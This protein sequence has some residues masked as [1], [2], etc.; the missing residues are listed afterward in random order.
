MAGDRQIA[1]KSPKGYTLGVRKSKGRTRFL[2]TTSPQRAGLPA[3]LR[4][5]GL[6]LLAMVA[7]V[8]LS[9]SPLLA[10][11]PQK[12]TLQLKWHHQFQFAGYY[13]AEAKGYYREAG[14]DVSFVEGEPHT[15]VVGEVASGRAQ[16]GV[17]NSSL[18]LARHQG[19]PVVALAAFF[20]HSPL[21]LLARKGAGIRSIHDLAGKRVLF[22]AGSEELLAYLKRER[23]PESSL[24]A[25]YNAFD[26][27][28]L[29]SGQVDAVTAYETVEPFQLGSR[30]AEFITFSPRQGGIDFYGDTLFTSEREL[31]ASPKRVANFLSASAR[32]WKYA[33]DNPEEVVDL[34]L[35]RYDTAGLHSKEKLLFEAR[36]T[37]NLVRSDLVEP[38]Y[39]HRGRWRHIVE[40]YAELGAIPPDFSLEGFLYDPGA[41]RDADRAWLVRFTQA[42]L[43]VIGGLCI[44]GVAF[45]RWNL[46][47]RREVEARQQAVRELAES[48][49]RFRF[50][51]EHSGDVVWTMDWESE[52]LTF[53]S[54]SVAHLGGYSADEILGK[55]AWRGL[56]AESAER[57]RGNVRSAVDRWKSG[58]RSGAR[59]VTEVALRH[60]EGRL[61]H[62]EVVT[63]VHE[64]KTGR[65]T[66]V[67]ITRDISARKASEAEMERLALYDPLTDLPNRR[68]LLDR[69]G[70]A[71]SRAGREG[72]RFALLFLDLD[73][74]KPINDDYGHD[75]GD[76]VLQ[77]AARRM[78]VCVRGADTVARVG[79]DEF[80]VILSA[81]ENCSQALLVAGKIHASLC[82]P[83][84]FPEGPTVAITSSIGVALYPDHGKNQRDLMKACDDAMYLAKA[85]GKNRVQLAEESPE[86]PFLSGAGEATAQALV[87]F[88]WRRAYTSGNAAIDAEHRELFKEINQL[89]RAGLDKEAHPEP[90]VAAARALVLH[91]KDHFSHEDAVL[92]KV[93]FEGA[94]A[95]AARHRELLDRAA[96]LQW[97]V[98][99]GKGGLGEWVDFL[100]RELVVGHLLRDDRQFFH[101]L[102]GEPE[103]AA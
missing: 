30:M 102:K 17:G 81:I 43:A 32:G 25:T 31:D 65:L 11:E 95:H 86:E 72:S 58:D 48:E 79:G 19:R 74:F 3:L 84:V 85:D 61:I 51:A 73:R 41:E 40:S 98:V 8:A 88:Q 100:A 52:R 28:A 50:I 91:I 94:E 9:P 47:L 13:A 87:T 69:L 70:Q 103:P 1:S 76:F 2:G 24:R 38:G 77:E 26:M 60:R 21:V 16:F 42:L 5:D 97:E 80:V 89:M 45:W 18:V 46:R 62:A 20:Q 34:I 59:T 93:G 23:V 12:V 63:T 37:A 56:T 22:E 66:V 68:T 57:F 92:Q 54:P 36:E 83:F 71:F 78:R 39:M 4:C 53:I 7:M 33:L 55:R 14:L 90:F 6:L 49:N 96:A 99:T 27:E 75:V 15:D 64:D 67:G 82:V 101:L 35:K 10:E 29:L 44:A